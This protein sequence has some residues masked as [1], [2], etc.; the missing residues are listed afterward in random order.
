MKEIL[1]AN[2][3]VYSGNC[4]SCSG[5]FEIWSKNTG[6]GY[7][8]KVSAR[9]GFFL[10]LKDNIQIFKGN[11]NDIQAKITEVENVVLP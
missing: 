1:T 3:W 5:G 9:K 6:T 7:T 4:T 11:V 8:F 2:G 10:L